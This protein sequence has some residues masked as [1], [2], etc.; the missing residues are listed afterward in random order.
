MSSGNKGCFRAGT[1]I[2]TP[3]GFKAIEFFNVGDEV[4]AFDKKG[5]ISI[6]KVTHTFKHPIEETNDKIIE[7]IHSTGVL[8][9]T[10]NHWILCEDGKTFKEAKDFELGENIIL[11]D[12]N[13]SEVVGII[14]HEMENVKYTYNLTVTPHHTYIADGVRVHNKGGSKSGRTPVEAPNSLHSVAFVRII[15]LIS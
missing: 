12:G 9:V 14:N 15:D 3:D 7:F 4:F 2:S 13:L 6:G 5:K 1:Q 10:V 11:E 8:Y